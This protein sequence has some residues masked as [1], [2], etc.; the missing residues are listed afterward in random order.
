[1]QIIGQPF[2]EKTI[3]TVAEIVEKAFGRAET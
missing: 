2:E 1:V 3:L